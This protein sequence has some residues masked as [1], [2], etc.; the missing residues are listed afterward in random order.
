M[1]GARSACLSAQSGP[2][3]VDSSPRTAAKRRADYF[4]KNIICVTRQRWPTLKEISELTEALLPANHESRKT[5]TRDQKDT[6]T[7]KSNTEG[8]TIQ[9]SCIEVE[10]VI[11]Q[12]VQTRE[13][14]S[15]SLQM[16]DLLHKTLHAA[17]SQDHQLFALSHI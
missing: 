13:L 3:E 9:F 1:G 10:R 11:S 2:G 14:E 17:S 7:G 15:R 5:T 6:K 8:E 12:T 4:E 16:E